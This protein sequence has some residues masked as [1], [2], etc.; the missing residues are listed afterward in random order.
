MDTFIWI[1]I[2]FCVSQSAM[3]SGLNLAFFSI[4]RLRL[5]VEASADNRK[6]Q[7]VLDLR[8]DSNFALTTVLWGN[9]SVNVLLALLSDSVMT[10]VSAFFFSTLVITFF[11]EITPQAYFSRHALKMASLLLPIFKF[12]QI[13]LYPIAKPSALMLD[14]W[15]G[16]EG[17]QYFRERDLRELIKKH[18]E[19]SEADIDRIEGLGA[20]NFLAIDDMVISHE[21]EPVDPKSVIRL[22]LERNFPVFPEFKRSASDRFIQQIHASS[23]KW[24]II[25]DEEDEPQLVLDSDG[26]LRAALIDEKPFQPYAFCHRPIIIKDA[27]TKLGNVIW[28]LKVKPE[29][30]G[31]DVIDDDVV[32]VWSDEKR[33]IITGADILGRLMRGIATRTRKT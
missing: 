24:V 12:Y 13:I 7:R 31:D 8:Q 23:K 5:E 26:F 20:L 18:I 22:P 28:R 9:V 1:G 30:A 32:L 33:V 14:R 29:T 15:L 19:A 10:G 4:T 11:G 25:T 2:V 3:F 16:K 27:Y 6:A 21:G 17:I